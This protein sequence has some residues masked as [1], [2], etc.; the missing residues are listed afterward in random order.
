VSCAS[1]AYVLDKF[2]CHKINKDIKKSADVTDK[3][4][5]HYLAEKS[6]FC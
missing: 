5:G 1:W 2:K 3:P 4:D 6:L